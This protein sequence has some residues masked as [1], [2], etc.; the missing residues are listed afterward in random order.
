MR[1]NV[2]LRCTTCIVGHLTRGS[3]RRSL[4]LVV[5]H[6]I[7]VLLVT[8]AHFTLSIEDISNLEKIPNAQTYPG[9]RNIFF[10]Q[11]EGGEEGCLEVKGG[12]EG[13]H[14]RV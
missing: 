11:N 1:F 2:I 12:E 7:I 8:I 14:W 9:T 13:A 3:L 4:T 5:H 6:C 10:P